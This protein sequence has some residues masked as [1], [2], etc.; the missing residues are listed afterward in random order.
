[1]F[2]VYDN[3]NNIIAFHDEYDVVESYIYHV[4]LSNPEVEDLHIGKIKKKKIKNIVDLDGLYLVRYG[5]TYVQSDYIEYLEII[6]SQSIDDNKQCKEVLLKILECNPLSNKERKY[7]EKTVEV[8]DRLLTES[9]E[10]TPT[11]SNLKK[12]EADFAPY[13]YNKF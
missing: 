10:Y 8:I 5:D 12:Y 13:L 6:S 11:L 1:M 4:K 3:N 7:I 2:C 9:K